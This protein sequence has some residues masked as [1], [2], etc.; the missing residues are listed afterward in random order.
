MIGEKNI[1]AVLT[2]RLSTD[3]SDWVKAVYNKWDNRLPLRDSNSCLLLIISAFRHPK[4]SLLTLRFVTVWG[5]AQEMEAKCSSI[6]IFR[7]TRSQVTEHHD[8][9]TAVSISRL[10]YLPVFLVSHRMKRCIKDFVLQYFTMLK[11]SE[12]CLRDVMAW[13][14]DRQLW[15]LSHFTKPLSRGRLCSQ[16]GDSACA[17]APMTQNA[18]LGY[19][20]E[21]WQFCFRCFM[22]LLRGTKSRVV[23]EFRITR[24]EVAKLRFG[25]GAEKIAG[26]LH[27]V[28]YCCSLLGSLLCFQP[29]PE[30]VTT[31]KKLAYK[32]CHFTCCF[33]QMWN[34]VSYSKRRTYLGWGRIGTVW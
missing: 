23:I 31:H 20:T 19:Q 14:Q 6:S 1:L 33:V 21:W 34:L 12:P 18:P 24:V 27:S 32:I 11:N 16:G 13:H 29:I 25:T 17:A 26:R 9:D 3:L 2:E 30:I 28:Y 15:A 22:E 7:T 5:P 4:R 8:V 10:T